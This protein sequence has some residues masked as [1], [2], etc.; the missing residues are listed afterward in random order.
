MMLDCRAQNI[1]D[2]TNKTLIMFHILR[3][4]RS[5]KAFS[6]DSLFIQFTWWF[7]D[8]QQTRMGCRWNN[9]I[10]IV[11]SR[12]GSGYSVC[13]I[14][15]GNKALSN[16]TKQYHEQRNILLLKIFIIIIRYMKDIFFALQ[17]NSTQGFNS[18]ILQ[19]Y[20]VVTPPLLKSPR[21]S[22]KYTGMILIFCPL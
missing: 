12:N 10:Q 16:R 4:C 13:Y 14:K 9:H 21:H 7:N 11:S 19:K 20:S 15:K 1:F 8:V 2:A 18:Y 5:V 22:S 3:Y 6:L 17:T